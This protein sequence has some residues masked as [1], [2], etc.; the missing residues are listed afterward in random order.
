MAVTSLLPLDPGSE[1][2]ALL[3]HVLAHGDLVGT[4]RAGRIVIQLAVSLR[5]LDKLLTF[6]AGSE[7]LEDSDSEPDDAPVVLSFDRVSPQ[8]IRRGSAIAIR[9]NLR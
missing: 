4:D 5:I 9:P 7:E 8:L 6:D 1:A 2:R 3:H